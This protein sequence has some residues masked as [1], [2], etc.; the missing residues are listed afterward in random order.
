[1]AA[2]CLKYCGAS[3]RPS[4]TAAMNSLRPF[5]CTYGF[6]DLSRPIVEEGSSDRL[7]PHSDPA[8]CAGKTTTVSGSLDS[9]LCHVSKLM[10]ASVAAVMV[11]SSRSGR[12]IDPTNSV[13]PVN[14]ARGCVSPSAKT[15][16]HMPSGVWPGVASDLHRGLAYAERRAFLERFDLVL[17]A[18]GRVL[19]D[20]HL[21]RANGFEMARHK[22]RVRV[23]QEHA[24]DRQVVLLRVIQV[25]V[26]VAIRVNEQRLRAGHQQIRV[27]AQHRQVELHDVKTRE[28]VGVHHLMEGVLGSMRGGLGI[29]DLGSLRRQRRQTRN[30]KQEMSKDLNANARFHK[31]RFR[32]SILFAN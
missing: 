31:R 1:M 3:G 6:D 12:P 29:L 23:G 25:R 7:A 9:L 11:P 18:A 8:P 26:D 20:G 21:Q 14:T 22:V 16:P 32:R 24:L 30:Q 2:L 13:S 4:S 5:F 28:P 19:V 27:V 15:R 10:D 17:R